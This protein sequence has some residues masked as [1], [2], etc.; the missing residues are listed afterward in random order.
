MNIN[1]QNLKL[2]KNKKNKNSSPQL[3]TETHYPPFL[4]Y[5]KR[6]N[7]SVAGKKFIKRKE[8]KVN[9]PGNV[10]VQTLIPSALLLSFSDIYK[11]LP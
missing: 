2:K 5:L 1:G 11:Y 7:I 6:L 3:P 4:V 10:T 8:R 9:E